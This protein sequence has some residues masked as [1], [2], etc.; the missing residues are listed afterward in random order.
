MDFSLILLEADNAIPISYK[1][2]YDLTYTFM[3]MC[4]YNT[5]MLW[6]ATAQY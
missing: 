5:K 3:S 1:H 4:K 2:I 6:N